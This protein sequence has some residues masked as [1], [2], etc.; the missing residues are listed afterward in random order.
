MNE[1]IMSHFGFNMELGL[2]KQ[3]KCPWC[4]KLINMNDFRD[5]LSKKEFTISGLC[6]ACQDDFFEGRS[7]DEKGG[8]EGE[9]GGVGK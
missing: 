1:K 9:T 5:S 3:N 7:M 6:Q 2:I 8:I 4:K